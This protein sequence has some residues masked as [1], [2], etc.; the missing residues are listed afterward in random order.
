MQTSYQ[1][2]KKRDLQKSEL[3]NTIQNFFF[4]SLTW[5]QLGAILNA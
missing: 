5:I 3:I 2:Y 1:V 4:A